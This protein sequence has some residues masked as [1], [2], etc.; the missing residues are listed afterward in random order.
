MRAQILI[1]KSTQIVQLIIIITQLQNIDIFINLMCCFLIMSSCCVILS[2]LMYL[3][4]IVRS[5][6]QFN[7]TTQ[8]VT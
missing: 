1:C 7:K 5:L 6:A 4:A 8:L 3:W 2:C